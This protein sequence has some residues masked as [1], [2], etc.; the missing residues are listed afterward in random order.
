[1]ELF[2][3]FLKM[4][5][6]NLFKSAGIMF[7]ATI[8][9]NIFNL[10]YQLFMV[11]RLEPVDFAVL[12]TLLS[13]LIII[14]MPTG[15]LQA[16]T[17]KFI[18]TFKATNQLVKINVF[19]S[20]FLKRVVMVGVSLFFI[21]LMFSKNIAAFFKIQSNSSVVML[22]LLIM[23]SIILPFN[24]GGLQGLQKFKSMGIASII[25]GGSRFLLG[26]I[27]VSLGFRVNGALGAVILASLITL[28]FCFVL[29]RPYFLLSQNKEN[30]ISK[31]DLDLPS[32]YKYFFP[33]LI[34]L[35]SFSLLTNMDVVLVKRFFLPLEAGYYSIAQMV[36]KI[37]LFLPGAITIVMFPK[38][39]EN[40][41]RN[42]NTT[43]ILKKCLIIVG[44]LCFSASAFCMMY[45]ELVLKLLS[46]KVYPECIPLI[47]PFSISMSFF[48]LS[49]V[50]L[51][52]HLSVHN[53]R[54]IY[55]FLFAMIAQA[56]LIILFHQSLL[57]V[58]YMLM[59]CSI[60]LFIIN[61]FGFRRIA[62]G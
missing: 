62:R 32:I 46:G 8:L 14:S 61:S 12:N 44:T 43:Y 19:M 9:S 42:E 20:L 50:F 45:P 26:V 15:A 25:N 2:N 10:L 58:L 16:V 34:A 37:I 24:L 31:S 53:L 36:G 7:F 4:K 28:I 51:Y 13:L 54:S 47:A 27:L 55:I 35:P 48:A 39:S 60:S 11:R 22:G 49:S 18:A 59:G 3:T 1:M 33:V 38:V 21:V 56:I 17:A 52:Y 23:L 5:S 57:Q 29:L 41:A 6:D 40:H 30:A